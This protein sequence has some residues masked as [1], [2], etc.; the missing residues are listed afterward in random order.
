MTTLGRS[1]QLYGHST[2]H[3]LTAKEHFYVFKADL[4]SY[5]YHLFITP[6]LSRISYIVVLV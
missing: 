5:L 4:F 6:G 1:T 2:L 3:K